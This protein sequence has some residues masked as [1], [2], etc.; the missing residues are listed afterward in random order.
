MTWQSTVCCKKAR[1]VA[2]GD[3]TEIGEAVLVIMAALVQMGILA[4]WRP[5]R[6]SG[7]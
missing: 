6:R 5:P 7:R 2:G 1:R 4:A 3:V